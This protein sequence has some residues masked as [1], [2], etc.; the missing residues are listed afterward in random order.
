MDPMQRIK[1][2]LSLVLPLLLI[3]CIVCGTPRV[4]N[5]I[6]GCVVPLGVSPAGV[7]R[8]AFQETGRT[9]IDKGI[10][11]LEPL[12]G[13]VLID[14]YGLDDKVRVSV[15]GSQVFQLGFNQLKICEL[16]S[17]LREGYNTVDVYHIDNNNGRC[18]DFGYRFGDASAWRYGD[19]YAN[20]TCSRPL[21]KKW[22]AM[23]L[24][25]FSFKWTP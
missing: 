13:R 18:W 1:P 21:G 9:T 24:V 19:H 3:G 25:K 16:T 2:R 6:P 20:T 12:S 8:Q 22:R 4:A 10:L 11:G 17:Q 14:V 15:N 5:A 23:Y 7:D